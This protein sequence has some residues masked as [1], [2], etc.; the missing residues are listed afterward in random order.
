MLEETG[1]EGYVLIIDGSPDFL[2]KLAVDQMAEN[3][4][5]EIVQQIML[6]GIVQLIFPGENIDVQ[7][8]FTECATWDSRIDKILEYGK[9]HM[10]Y[11]PDYLRSM[12]NAIFNRIKITMNLDIKNFTPINASITL[13]RP[14]ELSVVNIDE[15]YGLAKYTKGKISLK[16]IE[17]NHITV[18]ENPKLP[19]LINEVRIHLED[20]NPSYT[21]AEL[22]F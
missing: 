1:M 18:L 19:Q 12:A 15:D 3:A 14:N 9:D 11:S 13:I 6:T 4:S 22:G 20:K 2:H 16:F 17:G 8:I 7:A 10:S 5:D 21:D